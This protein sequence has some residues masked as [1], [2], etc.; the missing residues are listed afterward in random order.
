MK[1][2][3]LK[4]SSSKL[5]VS[6]RWLA[7]SVFAFLLV[8]AHSLLP[9]VS[10]QG[11]EDHSEGSKTTAPANAAKVSI[12]SAERNINNEAGNFTLVLK[13]TPGDVRNGET[14]QFLL[15]ITEKVEGGFGN[16]GAVPLEKASL[17][18]NITQA[19][20]TLIK[21]NLSVKPEADGNY[22]TSFA[23]SGAGDHKI[24][25]NVTTEDKRQF[26]ADFPVTVSRAPIRSSFWLGL[27]VLSL[28]LLGSLGAVFYTAKKKGGMNF[29]KVALP[30]VAA[31]LIFALGAMALAYF[32]PP[33]ETRAIAE[34]PLNATGETE[35]NA[36]AAKTVL[37]VPKESQLLFGIKTEPV[38]TRQIIGGLK[39]TGTVRA[40][41]D[42]RAVV[43]PPVSGKIV[44]R[45][46]IS[47]G[48][49][50]GR[51]EQIGY[52]EQILDVSGQTELESQ[53][54]E[55][56]A[57]QRE[58]EAKRLEIRNTVLQLQSQQADQRAKA[59]QARTQ[60]A[61]ARRELRRS[62][63][64][65]EVGAVPRKRLEEAQT[66]VKVAE[67]EVSSAEQQVKLLDN[68]IKQTSAGQTIFRPPRVNQLNKTFPLTAPVTGIINEIK[69]TSGQQVES[70]T[71]ILSLANLS[72]V[73][74]EA[75]V[76]ER[77][78]P[79]VRESTRAS[80][81]A[82]ALSGEVYTIGTGEGDG[83]LVS[84][85]QTVN[86][87]TRTV[88]VVYEVKNPGQR[89]RDGM[90]VEMTIDTSGDQKVLAVPKAA[91]VTEQGQT[92]VFVFDG[93]ETFEKRA[94]ALGTEGSD[95]YEIKTGLKEGERVVTE[96]IYQ[97]RS[98][99]PS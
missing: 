7:V 85:G 76:F 11:G 29:N 17:T 35:T 74:L 73:L 25:F 93:G 27:A 24:V 46:G 82:S 97:L 56:E 72:T 69:A 83:R 57:Q 77:D 31:L 14:E 3:Q 21:E 80:F 5:V 90:F 42:S 19:N 91:V 39:T 96:G 63:N 23:F 43:V 58:V 34:I 78:L 51:G 87:Q 37:A 10:A 75:Q 18:A 86:E 65:V 60:L 53:R 2:K 88:S 1:N 70:G 20:G 55:V 44:L 49:A 95:F 32:L 36:L 47:L 89:L 54:L 52:V 30:A 84:I 8:T 12:V 79:A 33:Q 38:A 64:L 99:Q 98:T 92:F 61:Q 62:E 6:G 59:N 45:E 66:A 9:A 48:S 26:S 68:Q 13:R 16:Q 81:T 4:V 41:P 15:K 50:V 94:V 67:Q 28:L 40:R 71:E 22:R